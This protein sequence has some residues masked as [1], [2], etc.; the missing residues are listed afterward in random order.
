MQKK[1]DKQL[2]KENYWINMAK[3]FKFKTCYFLVWKMQGT[4]FTRNNVHFCLLVL[5]YCKFS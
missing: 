4:Y 3:I 5:Q 1:S 2:Q